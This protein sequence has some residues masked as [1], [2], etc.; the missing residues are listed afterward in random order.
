M[1]PNPKSELF[2]DA[3]D[4]EVAHLFACHL[5]TL[6]HKQQTRASVVLKTI[7]PL[8]YRFRPN[9]PEQRLYALSHT[10]LPQPL[11]PD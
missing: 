4:A 11:Q 3:I 1:Q 7:P 5:V 10:T 8:R 9:S 2:N 6:G